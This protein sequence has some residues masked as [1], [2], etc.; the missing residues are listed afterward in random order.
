MR[1]MCTMTGRPCPRRFDRGGDAV[2]VRV[3]V[4]AFDQRC[5]AYVGPRAR[6][7]GARGTWRIRHVERY[8]HV[9]HTPGFQHVLRTKKHGVAAEPAQFG[10]VDGGRQRRGTGSVVCHVGVRA[11][12]AVR[13]AVIVGITVG[14][15]AVLAAAG[16]GTIHGRMPIHQCP[17]R[18]SGR[19]SRPC[20]PS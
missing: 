20:M 4:G 14:E 1:G 6:Q 8:G 2:I 18:C 10:V 17:F 7:H 12:S 9:V 15:V 11:A 13:D 5:Q 19:Q 3:P 16:A